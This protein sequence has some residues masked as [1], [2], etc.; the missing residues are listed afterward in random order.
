MRTRRRARGLRCWPSTSWQRATKHV[1]A[2]GGVRRSTGAFSHSSGYNPASNDWSPRREWVTVITTCPSPRAPYSGSPNPQS[3]PSKRGLQTASTAKSGLVQSRRNRSI[4]RRLRANSLSYK[5][6]RNRGRR[7]SI[8]P[9]QSHK[10]LIHNS[11]CAPHS[12]LRDDYAMTLV[13]GS[14]SF[15]PMTPRSVRARGWTHM[16]VGG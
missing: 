6:L 11:L 5:N 12:Q 2:G 1:Y 7:N 8:P 15:A 3:V 10:C 13:S 9:A 14:R 4:Y 16:R